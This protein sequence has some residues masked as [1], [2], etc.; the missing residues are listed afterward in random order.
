MFKKFTHPKNIVFTVFFWLFS[1]IFS[2][3]FKT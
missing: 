2:M 3:I 1:L